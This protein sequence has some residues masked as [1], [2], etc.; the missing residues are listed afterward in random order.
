[1]R[2]IFIYLK[3]TLVPLLLWVIFS[4]LV[5]GENIQSFQQASML[6]L[7]ALAMNQIGLMLYALRLRGLALAYQAPLGVMESFKIHVQSIFY[8][9]FIPMTVGME[10]A[11]FAKIKALYPQMSGK[12]L[13]AALLSDRVW[14]LVATLLTAG[15]L[16][17]LF[18]QYFIMMIDYQD[19]YGFWIVGAGVVVIVVVLLMIKMRSVV[20]EKVGEIWNILSEQKSYILYLGTLSILA[21]L[22]S[23]VAS[24]ILLQ[25]LDVNI[26]LGKCLFGISLSML[27][28]V[29]PV[30][31]LGITLT[32]GAVVVVFTMLGY[33]TEQSA[34]VASC[35]Y[36]LRMIGALQGGI[37]EFVEDGYKIK[38]YQ[39]KISEI[40]DV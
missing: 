33:S 19:K 35:V 3:M 29:I 24:Y 37:W 16:L 5:S 23:I 31:V 6:A 8:Q 39:K 22:S 10:V 17:P 14:S 11:R 28:L 7:I 21:H 40:S 12:R 26:P 20:Q 2:Y 38:V 34:L 15:A 25:S 13:I 4:S 32:E 18:I 1:M 9:V 27:F 30:A 36:A